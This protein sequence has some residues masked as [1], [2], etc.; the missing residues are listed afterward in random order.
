M[1]SSDVMC[2]DSR[3]DASVCVEVAMHG[4][5]RPVEPFVSAVLALSAATEDAMLANV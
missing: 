1:T 3:T 5:C 2:V 4:T